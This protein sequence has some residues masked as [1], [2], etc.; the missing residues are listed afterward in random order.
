MILEK[1]TCSSHTRE[2]KSRMEKLLAE[3]EEGK[4][5]IDAAGERWTQAMIRRSDII[6][7]ETEEK[8]RKIENASEP[9][10]EAALTGGSSGSA[11]PGLIWTVKC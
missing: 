8:K 10:V 4:K 7:A 5:C 11:G 6:L 1:P 9:A 3:T 2:C